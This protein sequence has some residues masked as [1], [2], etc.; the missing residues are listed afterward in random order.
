M[1]V[2]VATEGPVDTA[3]VGRI[4]REAGLDLGPVHG[5]KGKGTLDRNLKGYNNA[6]RFAP[7][8][9][10]RDLDRDAD[11][12]P[13]LLPSLL[14]SPAAMMRFRIAVRSVEAWLL[15]DAERVQRFFRIP[16][17]SIPIDPEALTDAKQT[18]VNLA[19][20]STSRKIREDVVPRQGTTGR[21]G[22]AYTARLIEF[23]ARSWRPKIA[24]RRSSSLRRCLDSLTLWTEPPS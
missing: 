2:T 13:E 10:L 6:A 8:V 17:G 21:V 3:V 12:P 15:A 16:E 11:C 19:R 9:V 18:I 23:A 5:E 14:P 1:V 20:M 7:W 24:A 22:P 4:L